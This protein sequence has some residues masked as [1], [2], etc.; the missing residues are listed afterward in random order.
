M[1]TKIL[2][3]ARFT[4]QQVADAVTRTYGTP[5]KCEVVEHEGILYYSVSR[6]DSD[7][8]PTLLACS[9]ARLIDIFAVAVEV[10]QARQ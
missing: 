4:A 2:N 3:V 5:I 7:A 8:P 6:S 10:L 9:R 1:S